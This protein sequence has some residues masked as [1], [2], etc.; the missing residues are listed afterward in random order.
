LHGSGSDFAEEPAE[1]SGD[2]SGRLRVV[3]YCPPGPLS[4]VAEQVAVDGLADVAIPSRLELTSAEQLDEMAN[5]R[6]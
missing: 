4:G 2:R 3:P 5:P 6:H 1:R